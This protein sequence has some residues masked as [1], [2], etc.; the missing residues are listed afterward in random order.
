MKKAFTWIGLILLSPVLLFIIITIILYI[1][2]VQNWAVDRVSAIASDGTDMQITVDH[3][4][5]KFPLDLSIQGV[6]VIQGNDTIADIE[7]TVVDVRILPL[8][9]QTV[10]VNTLEINQAKI[11][12]QS[13]ISDIQVS[14]AVGRLSVSSRNIDLAE[15]IVDINNAQLSDANVTILLSDTAAVDTTQSE[16]LPWM[17]YVDSVSI[18]RSRLELHMPGD[19]MRVIA[20]IGKASA[21]DAKINLLQ[22]IYTVHSFTWNDGA[23]QYDLPFTQPLAQ[24][25]DYNHIDLSTIQ[26]AIDSVYFSAP[27]LSLKVQTAAMREK[28]GLEMTQLTGTLL[29]D[30]ASIR[31]P[32]LFLSTPFSSIQARTRIDFNV[33]DSIQ[34]GQLDVD[35]KASLGKHDLM[36]FLTDMPDAFYKQWPEWPLH[37][38]AVMNG[39]MSNATVT[40][41]EADLPTAFHA[42]AHGSVANLLDTD[43]LIAQLE[44]DATTYNIDFATAFVDRKLMQ[45]YNIPKGMQLKGTVNADGPRYSADLTLREGNGIVKAKG[46]FAQNVMS[47]DANVVVERLNLHHFMPKMSFYELS[48]NANAKGHGTDFFHK[49]TWLDAD[50]QLRHLQYGRLSVDSITANAHLKDGRAMASLKGINKFMRG[51]FDVNALL[52][53][54]MLYATLSAD[55]PKLDIYAMQLVDK[56]L[57]VGMCGHIDLNSNFDDYYKVSGLVGEIYIKDSLTTYRP[58]DVGLT[59]RTQ[60]DTTIFRMQSGDLIVKADASGGYKPLFDKLSDFSDSLTVQIKERN[61]KQQSLKKMWPT[62]KLYVTSGQ[63]NPVANFLRSSANTY[64]KEM[65]INLATSS[66]RGLN[67]DMHVY[68]LNADSTR[69]DTIRMTFKDSDHG[70]TY[71]GQVTNNRRNPQFIFNALLDGHFHETGAVVGLRFFDNKNVLGLRIGATASAEYNGIRVKLLPE[72][73]T[74]GYREFT[75]NKDNY[76][77][78][79]RDLKIQADINMISDDGSGIKIYSSE[80][81][82]STMLQD[83]TVSLNRFNLDKLTSAMP[84][85]PHIT[86]ILDGDFHLLMDKKEKISVS[87]DLQVADM[88]YENSHIG[89]VNTEVAYM[90]REDNTHA[91]QATMMLEGR[92]VLNLSGNYKSDDTNYLDAILTMH[93]TPMNIANGFVPDQLIGL[94]GYADGKLTVKGSTNKPQVDGEIYLDSAYLISIPYGIRMKIGDDPVRIVQ[95]K[96]L[97]ENFTMHAYNDNPLN[98]MGDIDFH[99]TDRITMNVRMRAQNFQLINSKQ[100]KESIAYGKAFVNVF[101]YM[102]GQL[103]QLRMRG[104]IDVLGT[105]DLTYLLLDSP[106]STDNRLDELV[107]FT[108]FSDSTQVVVERPRPD[109]IS[110]NMNISIDQGAH[111]MCGLNATRSNYVDLFGGGDLNMKYTN[112]G[113]TLTGRY[114]LNSGTMKYSLPIIPLK[115]FS[116]QDGS[117]VEFTGEMMNPRLNIT[118][119]ERTKASVSQEGGKSRNVTFDC[120]V[121]ITKTLQDMGL[122]F[123]ISAPEDVT[124]ASELNSM[125]PEQRG[126]LAVTMLTTGMYLS[127]NNTNGLN[128]NA[129]LS[130]FLQK[131]INNITGTVDL[132]VGFENSTDAK[133]QVRTDYS[134]SFAKRFW[135]NRL[136]VQIGGKVS[137]DNQPKAQGQQQNFFDNVTMEYRLSPTSNQY[138]KLF[139]NQNV[140]DWLEGYTGEYGGGYIYKRKINR[141]LDIITLWGKEQRTVMPQRSMQSVTKSDSART[142]SIKKK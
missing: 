28:S 108:D 22:S 26:L 12:T 107:K 39:N 88:T 110:V 124:L 18:A 11:N 31:L 69:I 15:G 66:E 138:V 8:L 54:K 1:P 67:G 61:L 115:T 96:L 58:E 78:L 81:Q 64:F 50:V 85:I 121:S 51:K 21:K 14:G 72:R 6:K 30:S 3:I 126:K 74:L 101:A 131:E 52:N 70:L 49:S 55:L 95:S 34:P 53:K 123:I 141:L 129:A 113:M 36:L 59:I 136:K 76:L 71:Q 102:S 112:D 92:E 135:N 33:M 83:L 48:M 16:P 104:R 43:R 44:L 4:D 73:P 80:N 140:Y 93:R 68:S 109:G 5:L 97:L 77:Y 94:E 45:D 7:R 20:G 103:D 60:P 118:A 142:D 114:T 125:A 119:T 105:T 128:M 134:F 98:I 75:L 24:G 89:N 132:N 120:G 133:G 111:V 9:R 10:V 91:V 46:W 122:E 37:V 82:D 17:L 42:K 35:A 41:F 25:F 56:E 63:H 47:Y 19:S 99:D 127:D 139:Y 40:E 65:K 130:N 57:S 84:Y 90:L 87:S 23:L 116:I 38:N 13:L 79:G 106:I 137:S 100:T 29:M 27:N 2:F 32:A 62:T 117:Y 86:G